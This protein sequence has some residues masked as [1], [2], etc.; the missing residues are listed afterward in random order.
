[1][2][3]AGLPAMWSHPELTNPAMKGRNNSVQTG[4]CERLKF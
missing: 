3:E 1:M 4:D 2:G